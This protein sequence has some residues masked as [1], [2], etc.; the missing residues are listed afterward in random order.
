LYKRGESGGDKVLLFISLV[1]IFIALVLVNKDGVK[2]YL[3]S[4]FYESSFQRE[5]P[6]IEVKSVYNEGESETISIL[7]KI[8]R[9]GLNRELNLMGISYVQAQ[10]VN[11]KSIATS[12]RAGKKGNESINEFGFDYGAYK[13][14]NIKVN[15]RYS[16][17]NLVAGVYNPALVFNYPQ[18]KPQVLIYHTHTGEG[19]GSD[20]A[21]ERDNDKNVVAVGKA[22][23]EELINYGITVI[24]DTTIHDDK[25]YNNSY[26]ESMKTI[27]KYLD[28]YGDMDLVIDLHRDAID[29]KMTV[30]TKLNGK[31]VAKIMFVLEKGN[32]N[33][34]DNYKVASNLLGLSNMLFPGLVKGEGKLIYDSGKDHFNQH[35]SKAAVLIEVGAHTNKPEEAKETAKYLGRIMAEYLFEKY[36]EV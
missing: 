6:L 2:N 23:A 16:D 17:K 35:K 34:K 11:D 4:G 27:D 19:Y 22:L 25:V 18:D 24:H 3:V 31:N 9:S 7:F 29:N 1:V 32:K 14:R 30:T 28:K 26:K 13:K 5:V 33:F 15:R 36:S 10:G 8:I 12:S 20:N 21:D